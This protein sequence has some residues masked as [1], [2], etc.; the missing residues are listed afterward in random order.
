MCPHAQLPV[1]PTAPSVY[2]DT[3]VRLVGGGLTRWDVEDALESRVYP[4]VEREAGM[5]AADVDVFFDSPPADTPAGTV[6]LTVR[7]RRPA[8][9]DNAT[10]E[11][12]GQDVVRGLAAALPAA[13]QVSAQ[14]VAIVAAA[15][16]EG[17]GSGGGSANDDDDGLSG[18]AIAGIVGG[19]L[20]G[21]ALAAAAAMVAFRRGRTRGA[22]DRDAYWQQQE[23]LSLAAQQEALPSATAA[24]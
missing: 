14:S 23:G 3:D 15:P 5:E 1:T 13:S 21:L 20:A 7:A 22:S 2:V 9:V 24:V 6:D 19:V 11:A 10:A 8:D 12:L 4:A 17:S 16:D 18:G